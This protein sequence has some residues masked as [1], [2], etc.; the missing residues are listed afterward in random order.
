VQNATEILLQTVRLYSDRSTTTASSRCIYKRHWGLRV[1]PERHQIYDGSVVTSI[2]PHRR[3]LAAAS[4]ATVA[5][6]YRTG[7]VYVK[8]VF[9]ADELN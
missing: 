9:T 7:L 1:S 2:R 6:T 5:G 4:R 8:A 3:T